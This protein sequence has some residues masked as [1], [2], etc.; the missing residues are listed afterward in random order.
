MYFE[1]TL[2]SDHNFMC[3]NYTF[4]YLEWRIMIVKFMTYVLS[5]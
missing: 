1:D 3:E 5:V 2:N 4:D